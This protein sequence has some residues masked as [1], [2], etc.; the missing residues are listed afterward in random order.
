MAMNK[1]CNKKLNNFIPLKTCIVQG[2]IP[3]SFI[4]ENSPLEKIAK[5]LDACCPDFMETLLDILENKKLQT[6]CGLSLPENLSHQQLINYIDEIADKVGLISE[7]LLIDYRLYIN[8]FMQYP[9]I[10]G[11]NI[12][13]NMNF[14]KILEEYRQIEL[15]GNVSRVTMAKEY[16]FIL[17]AELP[18]ELKNLDEI[19]ADCEEE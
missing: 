6:S 19:I 2:P 12:E 1:I 11:K 16:Y 8:F 9:L 18:E 15:S 7:Q 13:K 17:S 10:T 14:S 3:N 4:M 5:L